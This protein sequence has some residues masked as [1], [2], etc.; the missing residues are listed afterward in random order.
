MALVLLCTGLA[1]RLWAE[2]LTALARLDP[3]GSAIADKGQGLAIDLKISQPVPYRISL[4]EA[5]T[6]LV[7]DFREVDF[8]GIAPQSLGRAERVRDVAW[9]AFAPGWSRMVVETDIPLRVKSA[10]LARK[11]DGSAVIA[12]QFLPT[13]PADYAVAVARGSGG[14]AAIWA[15]PDVAQALPVTGRQKGDRPLRVV[16]DPGHGGID[17]G[18]EAGGESEAALMLSFARELAELLRRAGMEVVVTRDGDQFVPLESRISIARGARADVFLSLHADAL[19]EGEATGATIYRM[20]E[21]A[22]DAA[23]EK[24]AE[25]HDRGGSSGGR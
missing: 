19:A 23:A 2:D 14:D 10:A 1:G 15:L 20:D 18:A 6:R 22:S 7:I 11:A 5:P 12:L 24:I 16:L 25:R 17:P 4:M 3:A 8:T 9:G 13:T 21:T